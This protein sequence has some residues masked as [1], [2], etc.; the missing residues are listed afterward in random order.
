M[1]DAE[2]RYVERLCSRYG[3][4][5][6]AIHS[7]PARLFDTDYYDERLE[8]LTDLLWADRV[9]SSSRSGD[10]G[11]VVILR[12]PSTMDV[13]VVRDL[14]GRISV[15]CPQVR[16]VAYRRGE[17]V[18]PTPSVEREGQSGSRTL[19]IKEVCDRF[20]L[21]FD[22]RIAED[23]TMVVILRGRPGFAEVLQAERELRQ[24]VE[25]DWLI[26]F[27]PGDGTS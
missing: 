6:E 2:T 26:T 11:F 12:G 7:R 13:G 17:G 22:I 24:I 16:Y 8:S 20:G 27:E 4:A 14:A 21:K 23:D 19:R 18:P 3:I 9:G 1:R 25:D 5:V 15:T 10:Y